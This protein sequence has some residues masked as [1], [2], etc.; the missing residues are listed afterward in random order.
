MR[1]WK[2]ETY[3]GVHCGVRTLR[4]PIESFICDPTRRLDTIRSR[5]AQSVGENE[6]SEEQ[7]GGWGLAI[8]LNGELLWEW[9]SAELKLSKNR[10]R[11]QF[12]F[13]EK[14]GSNPGSA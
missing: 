13:D 9:G 6:M 12:L 3:G 2:L 5:S 4:Q 1:K 14:I 11:A 10:T 8:F 7:R